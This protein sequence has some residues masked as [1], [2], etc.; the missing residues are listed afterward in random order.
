[1]RLYPAALQDGKF[2]AEFFIVHTNDMCYNGIN[3]CYWLQYHS[4][5]DIAMPSATSQCHL[6]KPSPGS[7]AYTSSNH[8]VPFRQYINITRTST[9]IHGPFDFAHIAGRKTHDS[10]SLE[11]W[12]PLCVSIRLPILIHLQDSIHHHFW[13]MLIVP[14][15]LR[16]HPC[17]LWHASW[18]L[19]PLQM[20]SPF[21][22][23][24]GK[25]PS[26]S[27]NPSF[28]SKIDSFMTFRCN[29]CTLS[30]TA[31]HPLWIV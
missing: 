23:I 17:L 1:M 6:V 3:Q 4:L 13:F 22:C 28:F 26:C 8:L 21:L 12:K 24:D 7:A 5:T 9:F 15:I 18:R 19:L 14:T 31:S 25:K 30:G 20:P 11:D 16:S 29:G 2:L 10:I 27:G